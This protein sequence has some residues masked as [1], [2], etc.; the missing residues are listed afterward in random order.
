M[1][2]HDHRG[3]LSRPLDLNQAAQRAVVYSHVVVHLHER[4]IVGR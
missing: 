3:Y 2:T 1:T 4:E